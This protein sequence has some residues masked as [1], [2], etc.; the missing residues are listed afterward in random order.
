LTDE[1]TGVGCVIGV[2]GAP[3]SG[4]T[5]VGR[6]FAELGAEIVSLDAIGHELLDDDDVREEIRRRFTSG[7]CRIFDGRISRSKLAE[8]V[9]ADPAELGKLNRIM[10]P[11]MVERVKE[12]LARWRDAA[13][14][15]GPRAFVIEGALLVEMGLADSCD[16]VVLVTAPREERLARLSRSRGWDENELARRERS[17]LEEGARRARADT[18]VENAADIDEIRHRV[19]T[20]WEEWT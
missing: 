18:V 9:F 7:V 11:R 12:R 4:K 1:R 6:M 10:H 20:L 2:T 8:V 17:Q 13:P 5:L 14:K 3:G 16:H 15:E 19:K